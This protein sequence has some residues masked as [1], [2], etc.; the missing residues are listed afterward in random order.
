MPKRVD[1]NQRE[2]VEALRAAGC[3]VEHLFT[4]GHGCPDILAGKNGI[5]FLF[6]IKSER[7][8]LTGDEEEWHWLWAGQVCI[9]R[10]VEEALRA[11]GAQ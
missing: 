10:T 6:E 2:I 5:N 3:T 1:S 4:I 7:G 8:T 11:V 9:V